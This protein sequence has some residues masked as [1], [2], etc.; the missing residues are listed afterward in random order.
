MEM[1]DKFIYT[2]FGWLDNCGYLVDRLFERRK[3]AKSN[4]RRTRKKI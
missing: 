2:L 1:L 4:V 3:N